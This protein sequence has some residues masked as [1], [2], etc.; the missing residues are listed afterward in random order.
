MSIFITTK[1]KLKRTAYSN[2][3]LTKKIIVLRASGSLQ[4]NM[5]HLTTIIRFKLSRKK[6]VI[7]D[8]C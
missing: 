4:R 2:G 8:I 1:D 5:I 6:K 3:Q 7:E